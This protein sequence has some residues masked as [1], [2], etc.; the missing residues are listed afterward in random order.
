MKKQYAA[1]LDEEHALAGRPSGCGGFAYCRR[2]SCLK[3][4]NLRCWRL[5]APDSDRF[6]GRFTGRVM[7]G[8]ASINQTVHALSLDVELL[9]KKRS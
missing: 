2:R 4:G 9:L 1:D 5:S 7:Q 6:L 8:S 3:T